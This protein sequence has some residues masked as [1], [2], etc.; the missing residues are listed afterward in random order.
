MASSRARPKKS[1]PIEHE[2]LETV[3]NA[4]ARAAA[5]VLD[6]AAVA[7]ALIAEP[8]KRPARSAARVPNE[9]VAL[10]LSGGRDSMVLLDVLARLAATRGT[11]IQRVTA[12][13]VHHGLS[14]NADAWLAHCE[15][16]CAE[17]DVSL[18][19]QRVQV[20]RRGQGIEAA[21]REA[22]YA[23]LATAA[24]AHRARMVLTA[25]HRDDR[26]ETFLLQW[27]RGA[28]PDGL[29]AFPPARVFG[30]GEGTELQLLR[31]LIDVGR[32]DIEHYVELRK[33]RYV[34][35]DSNDD[36][37]LTRNAIRHEVL[38]RIDALRPGFR[39]AAA[40]SIDL[41]AEAAEAMRSIAAADL[42]AC[43]EGSPDGMLRLDRLM[44]LP[45]SRQTGILR[46]WLGAAGVPPPSR[47][48]LL[49]ALEQARNK[50]SDTRMLVRV[51]DCEVRRYRG[52][53]MLKPVVDIDRDSLALHWHGEEEL[54]LPGW[55]G[56]LKF[57]VVNGEGFDPAW[58]RELPLE[59]RRRG[60]GER[61]KPH[62]SRPSKTLKRL[63]QDA[64]I[65]EFER[66]RLPLVWR[67]GELIF[68]GRLGA[69]VRF[70]DRDGDRIAIEWEPDASL[71][72]RA[73]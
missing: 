21:A 16:E 61:F 45:K 49:E 22:R 34:D 8:L 33:V 47:A 4:V 1:D 57:S 30:T 66:A 46:R 2:L 13:H 53:L 14:P 41:V 28:G 39:I 12:V 15:A 72:E 52:L 32:S 40:R 26:L 43:E 69:D 6:S 56:V 11:G 36:T 38:P 59:V 31:P 9:N 20:K 68:V 44:T 50:R 73:T 10:A 54:S 17:R 5:D 58:L 67:K 29:A 18:V 7:A 51:G 55:G 71:I 70:T 3:R 35:D 24:R 65:P 42:A 37:A 62:P 27:M 63:F 60:G 25:H 23:A 64:D 19:V 48:R